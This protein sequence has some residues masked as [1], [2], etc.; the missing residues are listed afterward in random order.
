ML[1][2]SEGGNVTQRLPG[3]N[4]PQHEPA[5]A[6]VSTANE[7][8]GKDQLPSKDAEQRV[9]LFRSCNATE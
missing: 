6:H 5:A 4:A 9:D 1:C 3:P 2:G 8:R 7:F